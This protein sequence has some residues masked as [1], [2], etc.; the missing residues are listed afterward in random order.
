[1]PIKSVNGNKEVIFGSGDVSVSG[2][3]KE[4]DRSVGI[5]A[6]SEQEPQS[7]GTVTL[8]EV[9]KQ[10][11]TFEKPVSLVFNKPESIDALIRSLERVKR[12]MKGEFEDK[13]GT[14]RLF[15]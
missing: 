9:P 10:I 4:L 3:V 2:G 11:Y 15:A 13:Y 6:L 14:Q 12:Y 1:V 5:I 8:H 7:I